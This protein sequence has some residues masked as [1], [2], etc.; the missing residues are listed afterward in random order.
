MKNWFCDCCEVELWG[1]Y[2]TCTDCDNYTLCFKC[3]KHS[4]VVHPAHGFRDSGDDFD[5]EEDAA[6][7][8]ESGPAGPVNGDAV[9][10]EE[11][12]PVYHFDEE[13]VGDDGSM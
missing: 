11:E 10:V 1:V 13:I 8:T 2:F 7:K 4:S 12:G 5:V 6:E 9:L 3:Y